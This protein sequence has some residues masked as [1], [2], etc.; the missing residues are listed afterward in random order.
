KYTELIYEEDI[1]VTEE[2]AEFVLSGNKVIN[3]ENRYVHKNGHAVPMLWSSNWDEKDRVYYCIARDN[4]EKKN[5]E[6]Q[7]ENSERRFKTLVQESSDIITILDAEANFKYVSPSS[8]KVIQISPEEFEGQ[9]AFD[10]IHPDDLERVKTQFNKITQND[11][12]KIEPFR[13]KNKFG[14]WRWFVANVS[15]QINEPSIQG[16]IITSRDINDTRIAK[17]Q[18]EQSERRYKTLVQEGSDMI[19]I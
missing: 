9:N 19:C 1:I 11:S 16:V 18:L 5:A 12:I 17:E 13:F 8:M 4:T 10:Y 3:F 7:L 14:E 6:L 15:N 2:N